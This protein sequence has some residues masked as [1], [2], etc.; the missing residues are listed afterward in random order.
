[1]I[2]NEGLPL[3]EAE[4]QDRLYRLKRLVNESTHELEGRI[5]YTKEQ[6]LAALQSLSILLH[7]FAQRYGLF[8]TITTVH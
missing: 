3:T 5:N 7:W 1:M 2:K 8:C 4:I 6:E